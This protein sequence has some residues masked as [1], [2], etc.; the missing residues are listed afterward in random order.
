M[1]H[2]SVAEQRDRQEWHH[3][4][5][6]RRVLHSREEADIFTALEI[7]QRMAS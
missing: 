5:S 6:E 1:S 7:Q 3:N 4:F 2:A